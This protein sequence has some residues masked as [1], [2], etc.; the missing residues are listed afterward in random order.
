MN[1]NPKMVI[2]AQLITAVAAIIGAVCWPATVLIIILAFRKLIAAWLALPNSLSR[3]TF[4]AKAAGV[5]LEFDAIE[6]LQEK[7]VKIAEEPDP[8]K[9]LKLAKNLIEVDKIIPQVSNEEITALESIEKSSIQNAVFVDFWKLGDS[10]NVF[11][12]LESQGLIRLE[13]YYEA[14]CVAVVTDLGKTLLRKI[15]SPPS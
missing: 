13:N 7:A 2:D 14:Q 8:Q 5:E 12:V 9:R 4:R 3:K 15:E 10:R 6:K 11:N 1:W